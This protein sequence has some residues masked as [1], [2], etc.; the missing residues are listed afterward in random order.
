MFRRATF[1]VSTLLALQ[2][3]IAIALVSWHRFGAIHLLLTFVVSA[4]IVVVG[5]I[6]WPISISITIHRTG[7]AVLACAIAFLLSVGPATR[8]LVHNCNSSRLSKVTLL[9]YECVYT[10]VPEFLSN[11]PEPIPATARGYVNLWMPS[12]SLVDDSW[13]S[14]EILIMWSESNGGNHRS[15]INFE[16]QR[17]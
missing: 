3:M 13:P 10:P 15:R 1:R 16:I 5:F 11:L 14:R 2:V 6:K 7:I 12:E 4:T 8:F 17:K 9:A